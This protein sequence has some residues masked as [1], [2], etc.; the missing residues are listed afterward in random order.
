MYDTASVGIA[1]CRAIASV[2]MAG[3]YLK[4]SAIGIE[5]CHVEGIAMAEPCRVESAA[6]VINST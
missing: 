3:P 6:I 2:L 4:R 1:Q 5:S